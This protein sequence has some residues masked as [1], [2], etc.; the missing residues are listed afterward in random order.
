MAVVLDLDSEIFVIYIATL[1]QKDINMAIHFSWAVQIV[2]FKVKDTP[3]IIITKC[4]DHTD[5]FSVKFVVKLSED[6]SINNH[7]IELKEDI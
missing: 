2:L 6:T 4:P 5:I 7:T 1:N 3:I